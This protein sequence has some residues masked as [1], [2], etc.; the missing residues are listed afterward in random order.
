M[1]FSMSH[2]LVPTWVILAV[3]LIAG[4]VS[5]QEAVPPREVKV[6]PVFFVPKG[7]PP[8][9][10]DQTRRLL[11]HLDW[12]QTR[13]RELLRNQATF[14]VAEQ[15]P[16]LHRS[17]RPLA[18]YREQPEGSAP[19]VVSELLADLKF[20]RYNC[21]YVL[22]VVMMNPTDDFPVAGGRPLN[23]GYNTGGGI[24]VLSSFALD[25]SPNFQSTLQ[26]EL[27]HSFGLPHVD[28]YG[29]DMKSNDSAMSY[30]PKHHTNGFE[31]SGTPGKLIPED[32]RGLALNQRAFPTLRFDPEKDVPRG[33]TISAPVMILGPQKIP[34][35]PDGVQITTGSG[36]EY[37]SKV[38][39]VVRGAC[40][41]SCAATMFGCERQAAVCT[42]R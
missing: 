11:R 30:N 31:P 41:A 19:Q 33:Y 18:F 26:H 5:G 29:Y 42:S 15:G 39:N 20:S 24:V 9:T 6:L 17:G 12:S 2:R 32:L 37:G 21:S 1:R 16:I 10:K 27:G 23:G 25:R 35:Q 22:L 13:Y 4:A 36:E 14:A 28:V 40:S 34:E 38:A 8:P 3:V 7:E